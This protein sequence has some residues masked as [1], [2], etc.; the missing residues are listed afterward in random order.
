M[1]LY[2][3]SVRVSPLGKVIF[4]MRYRYDRKLQHLD[5][6]SYVSANKPA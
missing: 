1:A 2:G 3:L 4:Q 6:G 5:I